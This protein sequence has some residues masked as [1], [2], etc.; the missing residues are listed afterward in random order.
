MM[1]EQGCVR[2]VAESSYLG[3]QAEST[4]HWRWQKA[5]ETLNK[6]THLK[7][8]QTATHWGLYSKPET[9]WEHLIETTIVSLH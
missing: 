7:P 8:S 2:R 3:L 4:L 1:V 5:W 6:A 9:F